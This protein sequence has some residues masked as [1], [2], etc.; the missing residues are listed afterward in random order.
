METDATD[1]KESQTDST[2]LMVEEI[3]EDACVLVNYGQTTSRHKT[4]YQYAF[5]VLQASHTYVH[6]HSITRLARYTVL[7]HQKHY[8]YT[9]HSDPSQNEGS[10]YKLTAS[11]TMCTNQNFLP[12]SV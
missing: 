8:M 9:V 2:C 11:F 12:G 6:I 10:T 7:Q 3:K 5:Y 4:L 1:H